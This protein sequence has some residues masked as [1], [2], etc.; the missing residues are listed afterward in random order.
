MEWTVLQDKNKSRVRYYWYFNTKSGT[1]YY[2]YLI[3]LF[4]QIY[5]YYLIEIPVSLSMK[6]Q[7]M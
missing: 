4:K 1:T 3:V 6:N 5:A 7:I 2:H